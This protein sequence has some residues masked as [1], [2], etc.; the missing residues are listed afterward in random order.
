MYPSHKMILV[1][2]SAAIGVI[3]CLLGFRIEV[4]SSDVIS[5]ISFSSALYLAAYAGIQ[6]SPALKKKLNEVDPVLTHRK[7]LYVINCY[8]KVALVLNIFTIVVICINTL[9]LDRMTLIP[10]SSSQLS[11]VLKLLDHNVSD[12]YPA[13]RIWDNIQRFINQIAFIS[14]T[15]NIIQMCFIGKFIVNRIPFDK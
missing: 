9:V 6:A 15:A 14:F 1:F 8:I 11:C 4:L 3:A 2:L 7:Q 12:N 5:V 13:N 10:G